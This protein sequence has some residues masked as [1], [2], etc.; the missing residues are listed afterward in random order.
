MIVFRTD[1]SV[2][3]GGG[4]VMRCLALADQMASKGSSVIFW[5][6]QKVSFFPALRIRKKTSHSSEKML[7]LVEI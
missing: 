7:N 6:R 2:A 4:H 5:S 1:S 3:I